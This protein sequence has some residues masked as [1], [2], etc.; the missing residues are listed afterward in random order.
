[1]KSCIRSIFLLLG[2]LLLA[3]LITAEVQARGW[4]DVWGLVEIRLP[5]G[6]YGNYSANEDSGREEFL[7]GHPRMLNI[8]GWVERVP[9]RLRKASMAKMARHVKSEL[10][11]DGYRPVPRSVRRSGGR[12]SADFTGRSEG[13]EYRR[14]ATIVPVAGGYVVAYASAPRRDWNR[15][16]AVK[17][18]SVVTGLRVLE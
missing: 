5:S 10:R 12:W 11:T 15:R 7:F 3:A 14:R 2:W 16:L 17:T 13:G 4:R 9:H 1:M 8:F 18:R 6:F